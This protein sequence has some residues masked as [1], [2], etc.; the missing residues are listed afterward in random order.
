MPNAHGSR[1][2]GTASPEIDTPPQ[3]LQKT[4][5]ATLPADGAL[6]PAIHPDSAPRGE[7]QGAEAPDVHMHPKIPLRK[8]GPSLQA[9]LRIGL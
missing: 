4:D 5:A 8:I 6:V 2:A 3:S 9:G 1:P 7:E